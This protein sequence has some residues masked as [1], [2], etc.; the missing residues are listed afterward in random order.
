MSTVNETNQ[1][2]DTAATDSPLLQVE[3]L[4]VVFTQGGQEKEVVKN[5]SFDIQRGETLALVGESGSGKSVTALSVMQLLPYPMASHPNGSIVFK[6]EEL[7]GASQSTLRR[8]RV[9][10]SG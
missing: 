2:L 5:V 9:I 1:P 7:I 10:E 3:G 4:S 6:G 8:I